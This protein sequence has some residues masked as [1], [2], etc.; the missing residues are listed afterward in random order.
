MEFGL[1]APVGDAALARTL[2]FA[3]IEVNATEIGRMTEKAFAEAAARAK[4]AGIPV[5]AANC[6]FPGDLDL[7]GRRDRAAA[8]LRTVMPR[9][10]LLGADTVVF[11]SGGARRR[12]AGMP[13]AAAFR[14]L[15]RTAR[16]VGD[17]ARASGITAVIEPLNRRETDMINSLAEGAALAAAADHPNVSLLAD[18]YHI[19]VEGEDPA[20]LV[21]AGGVRHAHVALADGRG[22]PVR[23]DPALEGFFRALREAGYAGRVSVE[24]NSADRAADAAPALRILRALSTPPAP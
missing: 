5:A 22:W 24:G 11:G 12:P 1:C 9:L 16:L 23:S 8:W 19:A 10:A 3:Y 2:G 14:S 4:D 7:Y 6:L 15:V 13:Y 20:E 17:C 21:R 18:A